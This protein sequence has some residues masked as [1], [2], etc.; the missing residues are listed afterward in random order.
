MHLFHNERLKIRI[1]DIG[2]RMLIRHIHEFDKIFPLRRH[3]DMLRRVF[4]TILKKF[5]QYFVLGKSM[6]ATITAMM[7]AI[8][9]CQVSK[10]SRHVPYQAVMLRLLVSDKQQVDTFFIYTLGDIEWKH[11]ILLVAKQIRRLLS[12]STMGIL[13]N[14]TGHSTTSILS[15]A[16]GECSVIH[17][18]YHVLECSTYGRSSTKQGISGPHSEYL[19]PPSYLPNFWGG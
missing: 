13:F 9:F 19:R 17:E 15:P 14:G 3:L 6:K 7:F 1:N 10:E 8:M 18:N 4:T 12:R 16:R 11:L 2:K 5:F